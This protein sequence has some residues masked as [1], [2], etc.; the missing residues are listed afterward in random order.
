MTSVALLLQEPTR[1]ADLV[2][3]PAMPGM[4]LEEVDTPS[5]IVDLDALVSPPVGPEIGRYGPIQPD[6]DL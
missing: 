5:L 2:G 1:T 4:R 6:V 3:P